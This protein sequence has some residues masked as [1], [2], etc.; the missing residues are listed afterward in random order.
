M[1]NCEKLNDWI[2]I[3]NRRYSAE[4]IPHKSRP[5]KAWRDFSLEF[6]SSFTMDH[7]TIKAIFH[8][9]YEN[10]PPRA[11]EIGS[12]YTGIYLYDTVFW[13]I[14]VP[15]IFGT[16]NIN[17][18]DCMETMPA[19]I[20]KNLI[21]SQ[22][23]QKDYLLHWANCIDYGYDQSDLESVSCL[24]P[25]TR[26]FLGAAHAELI[27]ANSQLLEARPNVKA[28]LG[29]RMATEIFL[30]AVLV[31]E[32]DFSDDKLRKISHKLEDAAYKCAE[33]TKTDV[34][35]KIAESVFLYPSVSARYDDTKWPI[36]KVWQAAA[37]TQLTGAS[38]TR[39]YSERNIAL[40]NG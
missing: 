23:N 16:V 15:I 31:Q 12:I 27:G 38:V 40:A 39:F 2:E 11:H 30:K 9:F 37:L 20:K 34:F 13:P 1:F 19:Q 21:S 18:I 22:Q 8:W 25:R 14:Y 28:I 10:S 5:F 4:G 32:L 17:A 7:P 35:N 26:I 6:Q 29:L 3:T 24:K 33:V 36:D